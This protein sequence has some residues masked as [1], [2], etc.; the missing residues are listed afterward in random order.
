[1][2]KLTNNKNKKRKSL[3]GR[4]EIDVDELSQMPAAEVERRMRELGLEPARELPAELAALRTPSIEQCKRVTLV[5]RCIAGGGNGMAN[6]YLQEFLGGIQEHRIKQ[7]IALLAQLDRGIVLVSPSQKNSTLILYY[8]AQF[9]DL[10]SGYL[11]RV[12]ATMSRFRHNSEVSFTR[13]QTAHLK[14]VEGFLSVH[15]EN[16]EIAITYFTDAIQ[17]ALECGETELAASSQTQLVRCKWKQGKYRDALEHIPIAKELYAR[18]QRPKTVAVIEM[19]EYWLMFL[20]G[21]IEQAEAMQRLQQVE[22]I[23]STTDDYISQGNLLSFRG[24]LQKEKG[25]YVRALQYFHEA[26]I[27]YRKADPD[28]KHRNVMR[29]RTNI[30]LGYYGKASQVC[31]SFLCS[32]GLD[33]LEE[34][35]LLSIGTDSYNRESGRARLARALLF[36]RMEKIPLAKAEARQAYLLG[37]EKGDRI[38]QAKA[39]RIL[40][41]METSPVKAIALAE[42][43]IEAAFQTDHRR[44]QARASLCLVESLLKREKPDSEK[45]QEQIQNARD[46]LTS[47]QLSQ[48]DWQKALSNASRGVSAA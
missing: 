19:L 34:E 46:C 43:A 36:Y 16:Y 17:T 3:S 35:R 24:R 4:D 27:M 38:V 22:E 31:A 44:L 11:P 45:I 28:G 29:T 6:D 5:F 30:A 7:A 10:V 21:R 1:M 39:L 14:A 41:K 26:L 32:K 12:E 2:A 42:E 23:L 37:K 9:M 13:I 20:L 8:F 33:Q 15:Y 18:L 40:C 48:A 25:D 47:E